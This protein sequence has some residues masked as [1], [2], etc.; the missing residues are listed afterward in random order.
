MPAA[1][2]LETAAPARISA[3]VP[4]RPK[5]NVSA[6]ARQRAQHAE[7]RPATGEIAASAEIDR[8]HRAQR[9]AGGN[10]QQPG[11]ARG[12]RVKPC[13]TAPD[14]PSAAPTSSASTV[15]GRRIS[16]RSAW[17]GCLRRQQ[18]RAAQ[19]TPGRP[20][21]RRQRPARQH[22][23]DRI[24]RFM[25]TPPGAHRRSLAAQAPRHRR[26][27]A[28]RSHKARRIDDAAAAKSFSSTGW[29]SWSPR[30]DGVSHRSSP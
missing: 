1:V 24:N 26:F 9:R 7:Q 28:R 17:P 23:Q 29:S 18:R 16:R 22:K 20:A 10:A 15:R 11:S 12:L 14:R 21:A 30:S 19:A 5:A 2:R 4:P 3:M 27:A 6:Q 8:D 13:S 25:A